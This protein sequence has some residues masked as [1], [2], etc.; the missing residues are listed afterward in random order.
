MV[1]ISL[2]S[3]SNGN[4][5]YVG[6]GSTGILID[7]GISGHRA[8]QRLAQFGIDIRSVRAVLISH[9]HRDHIFAAGIYHRKFGLPVFMTRRTLLAARRLVPLGPFSDVQFFQAGDTLEVGN[10]RIETVPTPHDAADG[11]AFVAT[12]GSKRVG[13]LTDLGH[14]FDGLE[15][16][17]RS[18]DAVFL[19]SNYD[20][21]MLRLGRYPFALQ[22]RIVG[23]RGHLS[24]HDSAD[25]LARVGATRL[26][27]VC[28]AHL[29]GEN[30]D[31]DLALAAHRS[32]LPRS[33]PL[34][35]ANRHEAVGLLEI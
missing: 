1:A 34:L 2:Q 14:V 4:C 21:N 8:Q 25:L 26:R 32:I 11:V 30:N 23:R 5:F 9:D 17:V 31:P 29:S 19:E 3:G 20:P 15:G 7:A 35:V 28:L 12:H 27:W 18:L 33:L 10:L 6:S 13:I 24:N 22:A 16:V